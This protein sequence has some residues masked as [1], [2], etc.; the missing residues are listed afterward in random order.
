MRH[1][2]FG[3]KG[4]E[5]LHNSV[6]NRCRTTWLYS[7]ANNGIWTHNFWYHKPTLYQLNYI[8]HLN[9]YQTRWDSNPRCLR[10]TVFKTATFNHS[11]THLYFFCFNAIP[12]IT[13]FAV[14]AFECVRC[15][16]TGSLYLWRNPRILPFVI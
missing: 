10:T 13:R 14:R 3:V 9:L 15:P 16:R 6:K 8:R 5:P 7:R 2:F 1:F 12:I 11:V 4:F